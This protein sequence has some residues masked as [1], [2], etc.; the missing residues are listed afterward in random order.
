MNGPYGGGEPRRRVVVARRL[1][2]GTASQRGSDY[3]SLPALREA[4]ELKFE[5]ERETT[6]P[7]NHRIRKGSDVRMEYSDGHNAGALLFPKEN[8]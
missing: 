2:V 3:P 6:V 7:Y 5:V 1:W 8:C 4:P